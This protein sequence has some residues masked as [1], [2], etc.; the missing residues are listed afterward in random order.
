[1]WIPKN[2]RSIGRCGDEES[3]EGCGESIPEEPQRFGK[4]RGVK[5]EVRTAIPTM[6]TTLKP[7]S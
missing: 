7:R 4:G 2:L 1:M 3:G 6:Y 5:I